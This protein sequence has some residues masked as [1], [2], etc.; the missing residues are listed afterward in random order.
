MHIVD[1]VA[2]D[3]NMDFLYVMRLGIWYL[4]GYDHIQ[5]F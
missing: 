5:F 3:G 1:R 4:V 2:V